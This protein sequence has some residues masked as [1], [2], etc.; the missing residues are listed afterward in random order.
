MPERN[1]SPTR[2]KEKNLLSDIAG[3]FKVNLSFI[4]GA[5]M[6]LLL[7]AITFCGGLASEGFDRL[8]TAHF[9]DD[10]LMPSFGPLNS[11]TWFGV[12][13]LLGSGLGILASQILIAY[14]EKKERPVVPVWCFSQV[15]GI[16]LA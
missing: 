2:E 10:T 6:L 14:L 15:P 12:M 11:V 8:S 5:P 13:S 3:L 1:F 7:L 9:L 4:K 16:S